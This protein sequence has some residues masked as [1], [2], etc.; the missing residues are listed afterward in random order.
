MTNAIRQP[1]ALSIPTS[2]GPF[3][4]Q[5]PIYLAV[6]GGTSSATERFASNA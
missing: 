3:Q 1:T 2:S 4:G 6:P 5:R